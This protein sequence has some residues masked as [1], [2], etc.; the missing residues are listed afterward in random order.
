MV[1]TEKT[2]IN[3]VVTR[4]GDTGQSGLAD[5][6]R[7]SKASLVFELMGA[8]DELNV[9]VGFLLNAVA[10]EFRPLLTDI[11]QRLFDLGAELA[12]PGSCFLVEQQ[13]AAL[14][15]VLA[16]LND[17]LPPLTEFVLP[18]GNGA[19]L[20]AHSCRTQARLAERLWVGYL[21]QKTDLNPLGL[22]FLN[23]LSDFFFVLA[24]FLNQSSNQE[25]A[26]ELQWQNPSR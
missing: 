20:Q 16:D 15:E 23:R 24:R 13:V 5:G 18:R 9:R 22:M 3:R 10:E 4:T 6:S 25:G 8:L 12:V 19:A 17:K 26:P 7:L 11:Q 14:E 2:R 21:E 1:M